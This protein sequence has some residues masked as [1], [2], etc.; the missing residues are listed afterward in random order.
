MDGCNIAIVGAGTAGLAAALFLARDGHHVTIFE[1]FDAPKPV[2]AGLMLQPT[3]LACLARLELDKAVI[4][5]SRIINRIEGRTIYGRNVFDIGY[6]EIGVNAFGLGTHR[7]TLFDALHGAV[8]RENI[9][10]RTS[11]PVRQAPL[12]GT[13]RE[14]IGDN[15]EPY[16]AFDFVIDASGARSGLRAQHGAVRYVRP[17]PFGAVWGLCDQPEN[18]PWPDV[19]TQRFDGARHMLGVL[20]LGKRAGD[21]SAK[22]ALFWSLPTTHYDVWCEAGI[23]A[24]HEQIDQ[25]WPDAGPLARQFSSCADLTLAT[26]PDVVLR[27]LFNERIVFLGDAA[28]STS[29]QLGQGANLALADALEL[30]VALRAAPNLEAAFTAFAQARKFHLRFYQIASRHLTPFFQS[31]SVLAG[32]ARDAMFGPMTRIPYMRREM[33]R[34]LAGVKN[35]WFSSLDPGDW[36]ERY[37]DLRV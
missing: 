23:H 30:S 1:Q 6:D 14:V 8:K 32:A 21:A 24:W 18:W 11:S 4:L 5:N 34:S 13:G 16:G 19:L 33:V 26:C 2:G 28:H 17:Y 29:P 7:A 15:D 31:R 37:A 36:H 25:Y 27:R 10:F 12:H 20:P 35:G 22:M 9:V 3:G